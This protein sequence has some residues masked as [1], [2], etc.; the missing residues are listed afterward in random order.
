MDEAELKSRLFLPAPLH[1]HPAE[2]PADFV[3]RAR[4]GPDQFPHPCV[5]HVLRDARD[6]DRGDVRAVSK[7]YGVI[8]IPANFLI[9]PE[10]RIVAINLDGDGLL[11]KL[12]KFFA[13]R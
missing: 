2:F 8:P 7:I 9:S 12:Q 4:D 13:A 3:S 5:V 6:T 11:E 1:R 10:G